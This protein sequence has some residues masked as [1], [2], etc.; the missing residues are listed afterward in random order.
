MHEQSPL[1][2]G[3]WIKQRRRW[4]YTYQRVAMASEIKLRY[5][6]FVVI[7]FVAWILMP[8]CKSS[9]F[10]VSEKETKT[11]NKNKML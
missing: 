2:I 5:K 10:T 7:R 4:I 8:C 3:E 11:Q 6:I 1:T 9:F